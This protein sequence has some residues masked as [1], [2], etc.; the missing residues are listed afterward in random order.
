MSIFL[1]LLT[2]ALKGVVVVLAI[3]VIASVLVGL[4][5][6]GRR[7]EARLVVHQ[8]NSRLRDLADALRSAIMPPRAFKRHLQAA[9]KAAKARAEAARRVFVLDFRGDVM[10]TAVVSLR[11]E[12]S[13]VLAVARKEDEV[14][15]RLES[16]GGVVHAYGL[17][18]SQVARLKERGL[19]LVISV[20]KVA[21]SGGYMIACLADELI[22]APF[23]ILGSI[24]VV[25][26]VPNVNRLLEA[27]GV[28]YEEM[29]AGEFKRTVSLFGKIS[30]AGRDK[31]KEQL[32]DTHALFKEFVIEHRPVLDIAKVATGEY[33]FGKRALELK[34]VDRLQTSDDYLIRQLE[35]ADVYTVSYKPAQP[36]RRRVAEAISESAARLV[37]RG[38]TAAVEALYPS[39]RVSR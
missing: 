2:F 33:W 8:L 35:A 1:D 31:F 18:A 22:A 11:D 9:R 29:T 7:D 3:V 36:W 26:P 32:E 6:R 21:A 13:A 19:R 39:A 28:D 17:V 16:S 25:A 23:A 15:L 20:D 27:H 24:G 12:I 34:L 10:A 38:S 30:P 14:L 4:A 5:R 37:V